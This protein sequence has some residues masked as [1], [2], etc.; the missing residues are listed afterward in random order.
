MDTSRID[1][2][3]LQALE[4]L[5][6]ERN[7]T[8]AAKRLGLSQPALSAQ[9]A[10][11]RT[12]FSDALLVPGRRGMTPTARAL[13]LQEPLREALDR[14]RHVVTD[15][16]AFDPSKARLTVRIAASDY[17]QVAVLLDF[18]LTLRRSA[19]SVRMAIRNLDVPAL[20]AQMERGDV[21]IALLTPELAPGPLWRMPLFDERYVA[22]VRR[23][24]PAVRKRLTLEQ[25]VRL[26]HVIVS[27]LGGGFTTPLDAA[28]SMRAKKRDVVLSAAS[29]LFV[30]ETIE[31]SNML[32]LVPG[33]LVRDRED[34]LRILEPPLPV[35]GFKILMTWH[36]R[37][38]HHP[39]YRWVREALR[40]S[41][42][43][44]TTTP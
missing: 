5:L 33:R 23:D 10:R 6:A 37:T 31:R 32:A 9:L 26:E 4:A 41:D 13:E 25:F 18:A 20:E 2:N 30:L 40:A 29:F 21:D 38:H 17:A 34:R 43:S 14:L 42:Q 24:H 1:L 11:L 27:P 3:L 7:V 8:R 44:R 39:G 36:D 16:R 12:L 15:N 28:L 19:P 35:K 22:V